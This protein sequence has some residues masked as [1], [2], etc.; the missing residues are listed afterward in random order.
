[1]RACGLL[2][3]KSITTMVSDAKPH[4]LRCA[5]GCDYQQTKLPTNANGTTR[6]TLKVLSVMVD[7]ISVTLPLVETDGNALPDDHREH[8]TLTLRWLPPTMTYPSGV[9]IM[10]ASVVPA[11]RS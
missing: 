3:M 9:R 5:D 11:R 2:M 4:S 1:M 6:P 7:H 8:Q 10:A